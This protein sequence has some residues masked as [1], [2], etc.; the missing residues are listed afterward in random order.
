MSDTA[1]HESLRAW[2]HHLLTREE[3]GSGGYA[4]RT[5]LVMLIVISVTSA[6]LKSVP[7]IGREHGAAL[8]LVPV[9]YTHL[10]LPTK[11]IV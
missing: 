2:A 1:R 11:R 8:D 10:T 7:E 9:S 5:G 3:G 6:V 4:V